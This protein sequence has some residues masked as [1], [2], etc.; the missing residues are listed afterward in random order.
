MML[1]VFRVFAL[2]R[3]CEK[4]VGV[5][6]LS[7][8][9]I[10]M[11]IKLIGCGWLKT[12]RLSQMKGILLI[13]T[14]WKEYLVLFE[15]SSIHS[16]VTTFFVLDMVLVWFTYVFHFYGCIPS[17]GSD[18]PILWM[19]HGKMTSLVRLVHSE[20]SSVVWDSWSIVVILHTQSCLWEL[21]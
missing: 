19:P 6:E 10:V 13:W 2:V 11:D 3:Y 14:L 17:G 7:I 5:D 21:I 9:N 18:V 16:Y 12:E 20:K 4:Y 15:L 1:F 8:C